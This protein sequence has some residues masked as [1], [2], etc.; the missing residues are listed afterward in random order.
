MVM[1]EDRQPS[2]QQLPP[3]P[4]ECAV[5]PLCLPGDTAVWRHLAACF[6]RPPVL[7]HKTFRP[8]ENG[9]LCIRSSE[10][11]EL[12]VLPWPEAGIVCPDGRA[13]EI[14]DGFAYDGCLLPRALTAALPRKESPAA[15]NGI[16]RELGLDEGA[17][18]ALRTFNEGFPPGL[19]D[20]VF[21]WRFPVGHY[22]VVAACALP[23]F[24]ALLD[25]HP[26]LAFLTAVHLLS[27]APGQALKRSTWE[28]SRHSGP[29]GLAAT[30][31]GLPHTDDSVSVLR[32]LHFD[33][34][35]LNTALPAIL[36][37][38]FSRRRSRATLLSLEAPVSPWILQLLAADPE[39]QPSL[40]RR[41]NTYHRRDGHDAVASVIH[42]H[43]AMLATRL[44]TAGD[45]GALAALSRI[46]SPHRLQREFH[47]SAAARKE[48]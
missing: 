24:S 16:V 7:Y 18:E 22:A 36:Q 19:R 46:R 15:D 35:A 21:R 10:G 4:A 23:G 3:P 29:R 8:A 6:N 37:T 45:S 12:R 1:A 43:Y 44:R 20:T 33:C 26:Q 28:T 13:R 27:S 42:M 38:V 30:V 48:P 25:A 9:G 39:P 11:W 31:L 41:A 47:R 14:V 17:A 40:V 2:W 5:D 34:L 32:K